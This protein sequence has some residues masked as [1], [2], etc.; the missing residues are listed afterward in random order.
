MLYIVKAR[1]NPLD[2]YGPYATKAEAKLIRDELSPAP[3]P[4]TQEQRDLYTQYKADVKAG[5]KVTKHI[6]SP[7]E[8][9][10]WYIARTDAHARGAS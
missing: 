1:H 4:N 8:A 5:K 9:R 6:V 10:S 2:T 3:A 7:D